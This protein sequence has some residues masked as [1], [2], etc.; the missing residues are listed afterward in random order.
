MK[1]VAHKKRVHGYIHP[2]TEVCQ[3]LIDKLGLFAKKNIPKGTVVAAWGGRVL[4]ANEIKKLPSFFNK[5][6]FTNLSGIL[7]CGDELKRFGL[8]RFY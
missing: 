7:Y 6:C 2:K 3:S 5:L 4:T 8:Y 1:K